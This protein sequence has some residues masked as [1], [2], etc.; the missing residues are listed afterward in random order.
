MGTT[1]AASCAIVKL[2]VKIS[3]AVI[4]SPH[5]SWNLVSVDTRRLTM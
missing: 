5:Y 2:L 4:F 3:L 1:G